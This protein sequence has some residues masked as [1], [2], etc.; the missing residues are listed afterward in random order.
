MNI[1]T[2]TF[3]I[4]LDPTKMEKQ[5]EQIGKKAQIAKKWFEQHG[6]QV[7]TIRFSTQ[8]WEQFVSTKKDL[9]SISKKLQ[10]LSTKN[11]ID[12]FSIGPTSNASHLCWLVEVL[13]ETSTGFCTSNIITKNRIDFELCW[14]SARII[15]QISTLES[16]GFANLRFAALFQISAC[17][18]FYPASF[19]QGP[20]SFGI[21][22]ENSDLVYN[23]FQQA[24][25]ISNASTEL[26]KLLQKEYHQIDQLAES[27]GKK[28]NL[29][30]A[31]LD[32]S[33]CSSVHQEESIAYAFE[34]IMHSPFGSAGTLCVA[35]LITEEL[36][37][38][39]ITKTGYN[40]LML[41]VLE[42]YGLAKRNKEHRFNIANLLLYSSVCGTGLDTIPLP[43]DTTID[44]INRILLDIGSLSIKLDKPLSA[45]LMPIPSKKP[46]DKTEFDFDYFVNTTVMNP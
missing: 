13:E 4:E 7:Q 31:G 12:Y 11:H 30:Y 36:H 25:K 34:Q 46:G 39:S 5:I 15:Q 6:Y 3:G 2:I 9:V 23:A 28:I 8:P 10:H 21:G 41:P 44:Q 45:R 33:I 26:R 16:Q 18:P 43:G 27:L 37:K 32:T 38:L 35:K 1:R 22:L 17:T 29:S 24:K 19:H 42:D 40:G 14:E 20:A